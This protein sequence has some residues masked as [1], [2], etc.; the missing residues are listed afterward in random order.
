MTIINGTENRISKILLID[1]E[2][3]TLSGLAY[4]L[5]REGLEVYSTENGAEGI[6]VAKKIM[7]DLIIMDVMMPDTDGIEICKEMR[8]HPELQ[9][10]LIALL[11]ARNEDFTQIAGFESGADDFIPKP[12]KMRVFISRVRALLRRN[13]HIGH[14][15]SLSLGKFRIDMEK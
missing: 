8:N 11:S 2:P 3:D 12:I 4:N 7:P 13:K 14:T 15:P 1:D 10:T 5:R 6:Q 9:N